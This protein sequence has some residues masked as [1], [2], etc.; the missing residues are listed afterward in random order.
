MWVAASAASAGAVLRLTRSS[1]AAAL[2]LIGVFIHLTPLIGEPG[3]P[4]AP[5]VLVIALV[6]LAAT[7]D[8]DG[9]LSPRQAV[10]AGVLTGFALLVKVNVGAYLALG[11]GVPALLSSRL[12]RPRITGLLLSIVAAAA[13]VL[14]LVVARNHVRGW[15]FN[16]IAVTCASLAATVAVLAWPRRTS[17]PFGIVV[18]Y[19][20]ATL[21]SGAMLLLPVLLRGTSLAAL[22]NGILVRP[23]QFDTVFFLPLVLPDSSLLAAGGGLALSAVWVFLVRTNRTPP[24]VAV[25]MAKALVAVAGLYSVSSGTR[26]TTLVLHA[27][28]VGR[29][30]GAGR[31]LP[32]DA[33]RWPRHSGPG[34]GL[35]D[36]P[37]LPRRG[38]PACLCDLPDD[39]DCICLRARRL[40]DPAAA[41]CPPAGALLGFSVGVRPRWPR[42]LPARP[43]PARLARRLRH[44]VRTAIAGR[45]APAAAG[46]RCRP[47]PVAER[48]RRRQLR[49]AADA[50]GALQLQC[51][52]RRSY[53][54]RPERHDLDDAPH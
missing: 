38:Q 19:T 21:I 42:V 4:Q 33:D 12:P 20:L 8:H 36:A 6:T 45:R 32:I 40:D 3:H 30:A 54:Q 25:A 53:A 52:V 24:P 44:R 9:S 35:P 23:S 43:P 5:L 26:R 22:L 48:H 7:W 18:R 15:A 47:L 17:L 34:R 46:G 2:T 1:L 51:L 39:P 41:P 11:F 29:R 14:P 31:R 49:H 37:G 10:V 28:P 13:C 50:A 27:A 16:Y